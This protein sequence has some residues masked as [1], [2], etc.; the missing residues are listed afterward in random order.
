MLTGLIKLISDWAKWSINPG[1]LK[2]LIFTIDPRRKTLSLNK[3][4]V[5]GAILIMEYSI[6]SIN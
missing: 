5:N 3:L 6:K 4:A 1:K 2:S